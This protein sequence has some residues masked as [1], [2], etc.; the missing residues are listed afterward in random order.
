MPTEEQGRWEKKLEAQKLWYRVFTPPAEKIQAPT[1]PPTALPLNPHQTPSTPS[2]QKD[3]KKHPLQAILLLAKRSPVGVMLKI[4]SQ[5]PRTK[6]TVIRL[7]SAR[8][9][10]FD[11]QSAEQT[12]PQSL[13]QHA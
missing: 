13:S 8:G 11:A 4:P 5:Q 7:G 10:V 3:N 1:P 6:T 9:E 12:S 2:F